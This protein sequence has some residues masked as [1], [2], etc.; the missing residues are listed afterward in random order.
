MQSNDRELRDELARLM[1]DGKTP[2]DAALV[3][4]TNP[5][6]LPTAKLGQGKVYDLTFS[7]F[8]T[9]F[10]FA[11]C[12]NVDLQ[13]RNEEAAH[14][15][16]ENVRK[17]NPERVVAASGVARGMLSREWSAT[18]IAAALESFRY[19]DHNPSAV[20]NPARGHYRRPD[21]ERPILSGR[22]VTDDPYQL[23]A[24]LRQWAALGDAPAFNAGIAYGEMA[25]ESQPFGYPLV[26]REITGHCEVVGGW[27]GR[28]AGW[29]GDQLFDS[30]GGTQ[31]V[32]RTMERRK[33]AAGLL[34]LYVIH[35]AARGRH[36][37]GKQRPHHTPV[38]GIVIP[39]GG[40]TWR[41]VAVDR[42]RVVTE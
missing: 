5:R 17:R 6:A 18:E 14:Q 40:P 19:A 7:P 31:V 36:Q 21:V 35:K 4:S 22:N 23:A 11:E 30:P 29:Q 32:P 41:R 28:R 39:D 26:N 8:A 1:K 16:V 27:T 9:V 3:I 15:L 20:G 24:Y 10:R 42:R 12:S 38:F 2:A 13:R 37:R 25:M 33:G 34:L